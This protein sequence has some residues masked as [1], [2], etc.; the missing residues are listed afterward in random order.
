MIVG[1]AA[2]LTLVDVSGLEDAR[3]VFMFIYA[4]LGLYLPCLYALLLGFWYCLRSQQ[5]M[6]ASCHAG[7]A[8]C[9]HSLR[10]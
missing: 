4:D 2:L 7:Q 3:H 9:W 1:V 8:S 5:P 10:C 6:G